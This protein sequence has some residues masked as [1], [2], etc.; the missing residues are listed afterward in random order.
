MSRTLT[1]QLP[2]RR[3]GVARLRAAPIPVAAA[4]V[5]ILEEAL[6]LAKTGQLQSVALTYTRWGGNVGTA[7]NNAGGDRFALHFG[8]H[9]LAARIVEGV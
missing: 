5:E 3:R 8:A 6:S 9:S 1:E 4:T 2:S 7:Y